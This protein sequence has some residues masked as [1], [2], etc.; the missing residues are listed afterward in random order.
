METLNEMS[1][2]KNLNLATS[3][4][5]KTFKFSPYKRILIPKPGKKKKRPLGIPTYSDRII[6]EAIRI[7]LESIYEPVFERIPEKNYGFRPGKSPHNNIEF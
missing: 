3:L 6:Q 2:K 4:K 1:L 5:N 7:I